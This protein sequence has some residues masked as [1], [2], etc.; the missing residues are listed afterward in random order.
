[1]NT[2][3]T[4]MF[5]AKIKRMSADKAYM[6]KLDLNKAAEEF[7]MISSDARLFYNPETGEFCCIFE[8]ID[9]E[10][11][12]SEK[13][14]DGRWI[15][16]PEQYEINEY[17][18]MVDFAA[19]VTDPHTRELLSVALDGKGA[20]RRFRDVLDRTGLTDEWYAFRHDAYVI[21]VREWCEDHGI[22]Y[23][24]TSSDN[25]SE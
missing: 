18:M 5:T 17:R 19:G 8:N 2:Q 6:K 21:I 25:C 12:D 4:G 11:D 16:A 7:D 20:F 23:E 24:G 14:E 10:Y 9:P 1:M 22:P 13:L 15:A 3:N